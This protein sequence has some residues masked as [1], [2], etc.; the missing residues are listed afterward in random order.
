MAPAPDFTKWKKPRLLSNANTPT[1]EL[2]GVD[3]LA[4]SA[5][6]FDWGAEVVHDERVNLDASVSIVNRASSGQVTYDT[7][8]VAVFDAETRARDGTNGAL[9]LVHGVAVGATVQIDMPS[10]RPQ[11]AR[12]RQHQRHLADPGLLFAQAGRRRR[13]D[14]Y[15]GEVAHVQTG[16][17]RRR[18]P[19]AVH[20]QAPGRG[21]DAG[22]GMHAALF[23]ACRATRRGGIRCSATSSSCARSCAG[24]A[25]TSRTRTARP[26]RSARAT[27][28]G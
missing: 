1:F 18:V 21:R 26:C 23:V 5:L 6:T 9:K 2:H 28:I 11:L 16:K 25:K 14:R 22:S 15:H 27:A 3:S 4:M 19:H 12:R 8:T 10:V 20:D 24:G 13:R 7:T 17:A